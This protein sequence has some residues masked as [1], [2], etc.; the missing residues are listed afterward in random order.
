ML[1]YVNTFPTPGIFTDLSIQVLSSY[2][3]NKSS[4]I[5]RRLR[6]ENSF[7]QTDSLQQTVEKRIYPSIIDSGFDTTDSAPEDKEEIR[8]KM[9]TLEIRPS[10]RS[11]LLTLYNTE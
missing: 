6:V 4:I 5:V 10:I 8:M 7:V 9:G 1:D 11:E 2:R 3:D